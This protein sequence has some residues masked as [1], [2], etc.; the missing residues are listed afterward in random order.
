MR[1]R[2][3]VETETEKKC[4]EYSFSYIYSNDFYKKYLNI[5]E[6]I[7]N[8]TIGESINKLE[9]IISQLLENNYKPVYEFPNTLNSFLFVLI[10]IYKDLIL[11]KRKYIIKLM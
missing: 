10:S 2:I 9:K 5:Q 4:L 6:D 8:K 1:F 11:L 3:Y 7:H